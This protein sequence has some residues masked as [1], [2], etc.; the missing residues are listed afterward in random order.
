MSATR[1]TDAA[2]NSQ[3]ASGQFHSSRPRDEPLTTHGHQPGRIAGEKDAAEEF[4]AQT[5]PA[6]SAP[7]DSTFKPNNISDVPT[8][9]ATEGAGTTA[10]S[11]TLGGATSGDVHTGLG[12]PPVG[13]SSSELHHDGKT[14][15]KA[16]RGSLEGV[17][18]SGVPQRGNV[19]SHDPEFA[20]QRGL[21]K[22]EVKDGGRG[23]MGGAPAEDKPSETAHGGPSVG[24]DK[25]Y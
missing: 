8:T 23:M 17:G 4:Q 25:L 15:R 3:G 18:A 24:S 9:G 12:K 1:N 13:Q 21:G 16:E 14:H 11:D 7:T 20:F 22:E 10:A 5:L 2:V 19:D 6:G